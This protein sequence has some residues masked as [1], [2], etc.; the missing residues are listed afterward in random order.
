MNFLSFASPLRSLPYIRQHKRHRCH[1]PLRLPPLLRLQHP[2]TTDQRERE[3]ERV[4]RSSDSEAL[5]VGSARWLERWL[6]A[7][8][9]RGWDL[10]HRCWWRWLPGRLIPSPSTPTP[11]RRQWDTSSGRSPSSASPTTSARASASSP[12]S[13]AIACLPGLYSSSAPFAAFL[14]LAAC[15]PLLAS[16]FPVSLT[17]WC[18]NAPPFRILLSFFPSN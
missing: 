6:P 9:S 5:R 8:G 15:G 4:Y 3:R 17:G 18:A 13:F 1:S 2:S 11:S 10:R 12:A 14:V 7:A 16:H